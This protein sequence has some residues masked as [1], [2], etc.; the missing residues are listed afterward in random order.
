MNLFRSAAVN[1]LSV[2]A[3]SL[4]SL[5]FLGYQAIAAPAPASAACKQSVKVTH[6]RDQ[7]YVQATIYQS[8]GDRIRAFG[9][10]GGEIDL[11][12][13]VF[14]YS[15]ACDIS[16]SCQGHPDGT[17]QGGGWQDRRTGKRHW[18]F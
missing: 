14:H 15:V 3:V 12:T 4:G 16:P 2:V 7:Y 17:L 13:Y 9:N 10:W 6:P 18:T 8:C 5:G 11:G 1:F